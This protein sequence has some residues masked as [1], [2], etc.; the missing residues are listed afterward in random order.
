MRDRDRGGGRG[1]RATARIDHAFAGRQ[2]VIRLSGGTSLVRVG[3]SKR[4]EKGKR[5]R[6]PM[7]PW[8]SVGAFRLRSRSPASRHRASF[9]SRRDDKIRSRSRNPKLLN[10]F[11]NRR[12]NGSRCTRSTREAFVLAIRDLRRTLHRLEDRGIPRPRLRIFLGTSDI[13]S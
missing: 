6:V 7:A 4:K 12:C 11:P 1:G 5:R 2:S 3:S 13:A 10:Y 8:D 9:L